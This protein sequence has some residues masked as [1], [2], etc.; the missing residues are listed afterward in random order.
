MALPGL[1]RSARFEFL[2]LASRLGL[3]DIELWTLKYADADATSPVGIGARRV[4][5]IGDAIELQ[6][7]A[8]ALMAELDLPM[9]ALDLA[10]WNW[11]SAGEERVSGGV[12]LTVGETGAQRAYARLGLS[13]P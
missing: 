5:G 7:R 12:A 6:R 2:L 3:A 10:L 1:R 9:A 4:F 13:A 11:S 8:A